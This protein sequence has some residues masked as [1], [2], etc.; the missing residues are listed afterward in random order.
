MVALLS[1][2]VWSGL[3]WSGQVLSSLV[4]SGLVWSG[5]VW[6]GLVW[7]GL[8][9]SG[10]VWSGLVCN[11]V[12]ENVLVAV[13]DTL[14]IHCLG[15]QVRAHHSLITIVECKHVLTR[16][17]D[18]VGISQSNGVTVFIPFTGS[19]TTLQQ[20]SPLRDRYLCV[21][22]VVPHFW[23]HLKVTVVRVKVVVIVIMVKVRGEVLCQKVLVCGI[24]SKVASYSLIKYPARFQMD[25]AVGLLVGQTPQGRP[26]DILPI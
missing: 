26:A 23:G 7:S 21:K 13:G 22:V 6:S 25:W 17:E 18:G 14:R 12:K 15:N 19:D 11:R 9:W 4:W 10:V 24:E 3:V 8:V 5:L 1:G 2:L 20:S 16:V